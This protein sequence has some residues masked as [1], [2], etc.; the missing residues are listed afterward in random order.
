[1][2][3]KLKNGIININE[4]KY[5]YKLFDING[6]IV[7]IRYEKKFAKLLEETI[8]NYR[9]QQNFLIHNLILEHVYDKNKS[10]TLFFIIYKGNNI[11]STCRFI[12]NLHKKYGYFNLIYTNP[13]YRGKKICQNSI[14]YMI[15]LTNK[16]IKK[17]ELEVDSDN[18]YA[19]KC[20]EKCGFEKVKKIY[21][22]NS[23]LYLMR[24]KL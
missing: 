9:N 17:Y 1:M 24:I 7:I 4:K 10:N 15:K 14:N 8:Q 12:Y 2:N 5:K 23:K 21:Y 16:Y 19:I 11:V 3:I 18:V 22:K 13:L 6:L 20:Y